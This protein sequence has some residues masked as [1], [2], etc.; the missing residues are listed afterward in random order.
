MKLTKR[1][2]GK[3]WSQYTLDFGPIAFSYSNFKDINPDNNQV[4]NH[5][6][7]FISF[8][9]WGGYNEHLFR[10]VV[11]GFGFKALRVVKAPAI[12]VRRNS[13]YH[14]IIKGKAKTFRI[15]WGKPIEKESYKFISEIKSHW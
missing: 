9:F 15:L 10:P 6:R 14:R 1:E 13:D 3:N 12:V 5:T 2:S 4:H 7:N 11:N 8:V